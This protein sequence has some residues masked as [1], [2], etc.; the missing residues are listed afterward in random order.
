[1]LPPILTDELLGNFEGMNTVIMLVRKGWG[2]SVH[3]KWSAHRRVFSDAVI[4]LANLD[5]QKMDI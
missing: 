3:L 5:L 4:L 1:M 2:A